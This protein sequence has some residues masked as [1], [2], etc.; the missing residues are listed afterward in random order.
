MTSF[1]S[2]A[3]RLSR[4]SGFDSHVVV[5][6]EHV[7]GPLLPGP[8]DALVH[9]RAVAAVRLGETQFHCRILDD[10]LRQDLLIR[11]SRTV[12]HEEHMILERRRGTQVTQAR[13]RHVRGPCSSAEA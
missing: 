2:T 10:T 7:F 11:R 13:E 8:F 1:R 6:E 12:V 5:E 3:R 4:K 9:R